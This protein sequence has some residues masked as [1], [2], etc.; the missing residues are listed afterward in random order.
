MNRRVP[1]ASRLKRIRL[2]LLD[3]DGVMTDG[4][5]L[6]SSS[7]D[8]L[9][10]FDVKDGYGVVKARKA[11]LVFGIISGKRSP[12]VSAR[13]REL[14]IGE[15]VQRSRDKERDYLKI[16]SKLKVEEREAAFIGD[17]D[18]D[19]P[20]LRRVGFAAAPSDAMERVKREVHYVCSNRG[21]RG[22]VR[23]VIEL[24]LKARGD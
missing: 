15:V 22:A 23:E 12:I 24:I 13:A 14:G 2:I 16:L 4:S 17:D 3:V 20:V 1:S 10:R 8:E 18:P 9:R 19:L 5:I 11:G 7:G 6:H 21:G